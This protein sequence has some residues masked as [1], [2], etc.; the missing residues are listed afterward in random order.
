MLTFLLFA[1]PAAAQ[2]SGAVGP[3]T[4]YASKAANK[5]CNIVDYGGFPGNGTDIGPALS[6]AWSDCA[7]GG[8]VYIPPGNFSMATFPALKDGVSSA[9]QL[10]GVV[11]RTGAEGST[12]FSFRNC[13]DFEFFSGN[14]RGAIQGYG[15]EYLSQGEYGPRLMR[16]QEMSNFSVHGLALVDSPA[17]YLTLD[18]VSNGEIYNIIM[19]GPTVLG[20]TDAIDVWGENV[21]I[22]DVEATNGDECVT[23]KNPSSNLLVESIYCNLSGGMAIGS[24]STGTDIHDIYYRHIYANDA[25]PCFIKY[26]GGNGT[27]RNIVWDTVTVRGGAYPLSIDSSWGSAHDGDGVEIT[28]LTFKNWHGYNSDN[29]RPAIRLQCGSEVPCTDISLENV[30][31]FSEDDYVVYVCENAYG[32]GACLETASTAAATGYTA[33]QTMTSIGVYTTTW[34]VDDITTAML[35]NTSYTIPP[36]PTS[37][38]PGQSPYSALLHLSGPGGLGAASSSVYASSTAVAGSSAISSITAVAGSSALPSSTGVAASQQSSSSAAPSQT[39]GVPGQEGQTSC[40][41]D[42]KEPGHGSKPHDHK[43]FHLH[44]GDHQHK[45]GHH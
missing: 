3:T 26:N 30:N 35:A 22:H 32:K 21:W 25:D 19:R 6:S 12:M 33:H 11:H 44:K 27:V 31:M 42:Y 39:A 45:G 24:L 4:S 7:K 36:V 23:V 34:M 38:Y 17:Y 37:F 20:G 28:N 1:L 29:A 2:L 41:S 15:N 5:V 10:D 43:A 40:S 13:K 8:L 18:T 14:S 9:V 16:F